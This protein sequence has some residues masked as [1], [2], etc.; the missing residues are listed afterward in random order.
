MQGLWYTVSKI[1]LGSAEEAWYKPIGYQ[2]QLA[3][4][5]ARLINRLFAK[6]TRVDKLSV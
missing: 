3:K 2:Y 4:Y 1:E 5:V 6:M